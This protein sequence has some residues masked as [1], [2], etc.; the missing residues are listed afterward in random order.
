MT[1]GRH[2]LGEGALYG[3]EARPDTAKAPCVRPVQAWRHMLARPFIPSGPAFA[4]AMT[5]IR[6]RQTA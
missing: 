3:S 1:T 5:P 4:V 2:S 6:R